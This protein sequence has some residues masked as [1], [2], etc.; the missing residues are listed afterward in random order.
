MNI[1]LI[2]KKKTQ[3]KTF[4]CK[5]KRNQIAYYL[6]QVINAYGTVPRTTKVPPK[7]EV[8]ALLF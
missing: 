8:L 7:Q 2:Q 6:I 4:Q 1:N 3:K 5:I